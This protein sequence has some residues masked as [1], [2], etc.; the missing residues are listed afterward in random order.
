MSTQPTE[1]AITATMLEAC[2][3]QSTSIICITEY[4]D[5]AAAVSA[6]GTQEMTLYYPTGVYHFASDLIFPNN[7]TLLFAKGAMFDVIEGVEI[8]IKGCILAGLWQIFSGSGAVRGTPRVECYYPQW[9]GAQGDGTTDDSAAIRRTIKSAYSNATTPTV[10]KFPKGVYLVSQ[11][12]NLPQGVII[13]GYDAILKA[14]DASLNPVLRVFNANHPEAPKLRLFHIFG[15]A[16]E[17]D[18]NDLRNVE[19]GITIDSTYQG[20]TLSTLRDCRIYFFKVGVELSPGSRMITFDNCQ[21]TAGKYGLHIKACSNFTGD[22]WIRSCQIEVERGIG[23]YVS[24]TGN[25]ATVA[26]IHV[27]DCVIYGLGLHA[28]CDNN[29]SVINDFFLHNVA[30]DG[31]NEGWLMHFK[32]SHNHVVGSGVIQISNIWLNACDHGIYFEHV[33]GASITNGKISSVNYQAVVFDNS[34]HC[35]M[36]S[37]TMFSCNKTRNGG[38]VIKLTGKLTVKTKVRGCSIYNSEDANDLPIVIETG[39]TKCVITENVTDTIYPY[40]NQGTGTV[41]RDNVGRD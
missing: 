1:S 23:I 25:G 24:S 18:C 32:G 15:L 6:I 27:S 9:F 28:I 37:V 36:N 34:H 21:I 3:Q 17:G 30:V 8:A 16:I 29:L 33:H 39:A 14:A 11:T 10:V 2:S 41:L 22:C 13:Y 35:A 40:F 26:G 12:I 5:S 4:A 20:G 19:V 38:G 7:I 31:P